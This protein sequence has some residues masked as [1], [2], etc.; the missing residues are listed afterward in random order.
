[1]AVT[2]DVRTRKPTTT[3]L[4]VPQEPGAGLTAN[5]YGSSYAHGDPHV[6]TGDGLKFD[7]SL[8]GEF[9]GFRSRSGDFALHTRVA[10]GL[11]DFKHTFNVA[12]GL[13]MDGA[14]VIYDARTRRLTV[15]GKE[16]WLKAGESKVLPNGM[17]I[18][19]LQRGWEVTTRLGDRVVLTP[20]GDHVDFKVE[21]GPGRSD[22]DLAGALG[23]FDADGQ[24]ENDQRD[25]EGRVQTPTTGPESEA[26]FL[27]GW[28]VRAGER[29]LPLEQ[30][31]PHPLPRG[32]VVEDQ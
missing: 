11:V 5:A 14:V 8:I 4:D 27:E 26:A 13:R 2:K 12:V 10:P 1:V 29:V 9:I 21:P 20:V 30:A 32:M 15:D 28:R 16:L 22:G 6:I 23:V 31:G 3:R 24:P 18:L 7:L 25:R 19:G 17:R